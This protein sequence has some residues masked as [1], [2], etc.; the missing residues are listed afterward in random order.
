MEHEA[1]RVRARIRAGE[2]LVGTGEPADF[3]LGPLGNGRE[4][5][6]RCLRHRPQ[7][8]GGIGGANEGFTDQE[9]RQPGSAG[10]GNVGGVGDAA[11][12][13]RDRVGGQ[14][15]G[16][17]HRG[18]KVGVEGGKVAVVDADEGRAEARELLEIGF[19]V[20]L[21][22]ALQ[23]QFMRERMQTD[24]R[25]RVEEADDQQQRIRAH[26][27]RG[28][29]R[30]LAQDEVLAQHRQGDGGTR[31]PEIVGAALEECGLGQNRD[32]GGSARFVAAGEVGGIEV[33]AEIALG[34]RGAL[35]LGDDARRRR[36]RQCRQQGSA[37]FPGPCADGRQ[38]HVERRVAARL[39][40]GGADGSDDTV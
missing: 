27:R 26:H 8:R 20:D 15:S 3:R 39:G 11:Q 38:Q 16:Q 40:F 13:D 6:I 36:R 4:T 18:A 17:A 2:G 32:R 21:H 22:E 33:R 35:D 28:R 30:V 25:G 12:G 31:G 19:V 34:G 23:A 7:Q 5:A 9:A 14:L 10:G 37:R 24:E 1:N 29:N